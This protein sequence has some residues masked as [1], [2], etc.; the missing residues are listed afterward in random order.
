[1]PE[2]EQDTFSVFQ[3]NTDGVKQRITTVR[4]RSNEV[5]NYDIKVPLN[6]VY[7]MARTGK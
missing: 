1:M 2:G 4:K 6:F 7:A 3:N 5:S